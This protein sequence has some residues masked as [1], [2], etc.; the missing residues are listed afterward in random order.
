MPHL[1]EMKPIEEISYFAQKTYPM[2]P[3]NAKPIGKVISSLLV[4]VVLSL[5]ASAQSPG[6]AH[7]YSGADYSSLYT[8]SNE[9]L[10]DIDFIATDQDRD[11]GV[12]EGAKGGITV[13][14]EFIEGFEN[15]LQV[16]TTF[17]DN[18]DGPSDYRAQFGLALKAR[19]SDLR[20]D[21]IELEEPEPDDD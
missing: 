13:V 7:F 11:N 12:V 17:S 3:I 14:V 1:L 19:I 2:S 5:S 16:K 21:E 15:E 8:A 6:V 9:A 20:S 18:A 4:A 10:A